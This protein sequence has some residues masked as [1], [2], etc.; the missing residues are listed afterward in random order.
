MAFLTPDEMG[1]VIYDYQ[2]EQISDGDETIMPQAVD[3]A[4]DE[5][6]GYLTPNSKKSWYDGRPLYNVA[7]IFAAVGPARNAFILQIIKSVAKYHFIELCNADVLYERAKQNYD[8]AIAKLKDLANGTIT[9]K[10]LPLIEDEEPEVPVD[11]TLPYRAG[12]RLK[13]NHE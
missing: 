8:R 1:S 9:I 2:I 6:R 13:F 5:V 3:A 12:S 7:L 11:E 4:I 10:S